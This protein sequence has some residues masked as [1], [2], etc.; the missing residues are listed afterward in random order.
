MNSAFCVCFINFSG[1]KCRMAS[2]NL[3][4]QSSCYALNKTFDCKSPAHVLSAQQCNDYNCTRGCGS[5]Q[6]CGQQCDAGSNSCHLECERRPKLKQDCNNSVKCD[7]DCHG[8]D[9][10]QN[11]NAG[12]PKCS[13]ECDRANDC[14]QNCN[15]GECDMECYGENCVQQCNVNTIKC[16]LRCNSKQQCKQYCNDGK[17]DMECQGQNCV[18]RCNS[19]TRKCSL[20]CHSNQSCTQICNQ[21]ECTLEC[22]GKNCWQQW[23]GNERSCQ[24]NCQVANDSERCEHNCF[25][26]TKKCT[27][28]ATTIKKTTLDLARVNYHRCRHYCTGEQ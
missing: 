4:C 6:N 5:T 16:S 18:Q 15:N 14:Q 9:C 12:A 21:G 13:L 17:C 11:C 3:G 19:G 28:T 7:M 25:A 27:S 24:P 23:Q 10:E 1:E 8:Q 26:D 2:A 20:Q 22:H